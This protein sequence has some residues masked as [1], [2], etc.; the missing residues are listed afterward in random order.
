[1]SLR[2]KWSE[3]TQWPLWAERRALGC[4][5]SARNDRILKK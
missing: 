2:R 3:A 5:A 1:M 4:F